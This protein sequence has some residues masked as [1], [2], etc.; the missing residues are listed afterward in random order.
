MID[1]LET[2]IEVPLQVSFNKN[3]LS[4][5]PYSLDELSTAFDFLIRQDV[6]DKK[7]DKQFLTQ[8]SDGLF[9]VTHPDSASIFSLSLFI[10]EEQ[11]NHFLEELNGTP[12][13]KTNRKTEG[14]KELESN[15]PKDEDIVFQIEYSGRKCTLLKKG[16]V[17][18]LLSRTIFE[19][20]NDRVMTFLINNPN[21]DIPIDE[22]IKQ[23]GDTNATGTKILGKTIHQ[24]INALG[25]KGD[26]QK[27][28][29]D[30]NNKGSLCF[31]NP[32]T[33][34]RLRQVGLDYLQF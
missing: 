23:A 14:A 8:I 26:L 27:A 1:A 33:S 17:V 11:F 29:F 9:E 22:L 6:L 24:I 31:H 15:P 34:L 3:Q 4:T 30:K 2:Q 10:N 28:F 21:Q 7:S 13:T 12:S 32:V 16:K 19:G 5:K 25:I 18:N 20:E